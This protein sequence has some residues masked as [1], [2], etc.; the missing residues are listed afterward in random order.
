MAKSSQKQIQADEIKILKE[1]RKN[2]RLSY[3]NLAVKCGFSRQK[4]WRLV[5]DLEKNKTMF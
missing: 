5:N 3:N 1:L 4:V 2:S